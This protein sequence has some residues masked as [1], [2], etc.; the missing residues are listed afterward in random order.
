M[1]KQIFNILFLMVAVSTFSFGQFGLSAGVLYGTESELGFT[2]RVNY[3]IN[4][5]ISIFA[6]YSLLSSESEKDPVSGLEASASLTSF[7]IDGHYHFS[8]GTTRPYALAGL[9]IWSA[10]INILGIKASDSETGFNVGAG[11]I[12]GLSDKFSL[13]LEGKYVIIDGG[14]AVFTAGAHYAF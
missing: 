11:V 9:S 1:K 6:G 13:F 12:H 5:K 4:S 14:Q 2:G 10:S 7:D 3:D 8:E